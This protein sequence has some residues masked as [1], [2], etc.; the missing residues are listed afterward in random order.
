[1]TEID[2]NQLDT[3]PDTSPDPSQRRPIRSYVIR[4]GRLTSSQ[5]KALENYS[6][7]F[8]IEYRPQPLNPQS[9]FGNNNPVI[10]EIGFGMG[11]SL[12][13][14]ASTMPENNFIGIEVHKPGIGKLLMGMGRDAVNNIRVINHDAKEVMEHCFEDGSLD[15][16]QIF[17]PDPWHKK[18]HHK[19]RLIQ[20]E[21]VDLLTQKLKPGGQLHLATDWQPYA[22]QMLEVLEN[23]DRLVNEA[24]V[25]NYSTPGNRP[26]TKFENRGRK[27]GHGVWDVNFRRA[28]D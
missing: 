23:Q 21:F 9:L 17:F 5:R 19:R 3:L 16:V 24:G 18:R 11:D 14:M 7:E 15:G 4:G 10:V 8:V 27:L 2:K 12:L 22:E 6:A 26:A 20:A 28:E 25:G 13:T 1:M